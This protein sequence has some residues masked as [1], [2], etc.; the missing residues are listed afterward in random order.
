MTENTENS[1]L[2]N[3]DTVSWQ[4]TIPP[5]IRRKRAAIRLVVA[6]AIAAF[7]FTWDFQ[8]VN[9]IINHCLGLRSFFALV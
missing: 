9:L 1:S 3:D 2:K 6:I 7:F 5:K 8:M 4:E